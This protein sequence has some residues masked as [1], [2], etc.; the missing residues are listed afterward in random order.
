MKVTERE[1]TFINDD[2]S[3]IT[4]ENNSGEDNHCVFREFENFL[5][6]KRFDE[7]D[8]NNVR[9]LKGSHSF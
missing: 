1:Q 4:Y 3:N 6:T 9:K 5:G 2:E 8:T 7:K